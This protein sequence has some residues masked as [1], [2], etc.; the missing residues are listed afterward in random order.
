[1]GFHGLIVISFP[2][3]LG[4]GMVI[5]N[6]QWRSRHDNQIGKIGNSDLDSGF[7]QTFNVL[8]LDRSSK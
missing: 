6:L 1:M 3:I 2:E 7:S 4:E 8:K 5:G